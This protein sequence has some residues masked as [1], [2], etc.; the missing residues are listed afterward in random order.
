MKCEQ[1]FRL[2]P[3]E[4]ARSCCE[5]IIIFARHALT[6]K[7][8]VSQNR[9]MR[10]RQLVEKGI[11]GGGRCERIR[12]SDPFLPKEVRYQAALHTEAEDNTRAP[13]QRQRGEGTPGFL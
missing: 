6:K 12:T 9:A 4:A 1:D 10:E 2:P 3:I 7:C 13:G 8:G 11:P 5:P